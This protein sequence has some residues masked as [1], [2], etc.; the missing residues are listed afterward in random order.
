MATTFA[1][2][3]TLLSVQVKLTD[4]EF[5]IVFVPRSLPF[6]LS[7]TDSRACV[8][9]CTLTPKVFSLLDGNWK[10]EIEGF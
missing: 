2:F 4:P 7:D 5:V 10:L 1:P 8:P 9:C 3:G 6:T